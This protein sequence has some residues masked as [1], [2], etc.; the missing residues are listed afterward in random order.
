MTSGSFCISLH[1]PARERS[2]GK[3]SSILKEVREVNI[4]RRYNKYSHHLYPNI[5]QVYLAGNE[6]CISDS[7]DPATLCFLPSFQKDRAC[8]A[9]GKLCMQWSHQG[10]S[11]VWHKRLVTWLLGTVC[12]VVGCR[13][14]ENRQV[15]CTCT[16]P[17][18]RCSCM[19]LLN[20]SKTQRPDR[21]VCS[22]FP[23]TL[24]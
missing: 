3:H 12:T 15:C 9:A 8:T 7:R 21:T 19:L 24:L 13:A 14:Q 18:Q 17:F 5:K 16:S 20:T 6:V 11:C 23:T 1:S 4:I 10:H 2:G 22:S